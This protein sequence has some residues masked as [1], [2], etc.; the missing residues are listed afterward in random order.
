M[1][2]TF[3]TVGEGMMRSPRFEAM[4]ALLSLTSMV[5]PVESQNETADMST[6]MLSGASP[7]T[8]VNSAST[9]LDVS[10]STSPATQTVTSSGAVRADVTEN[11]AAAESMVMPAPSHYLG[12]Q[13]SPNP[14]QRRDRMVTTQQR[15]HPPYTGYS[16]DVCPQPER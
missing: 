5:S 3:R 4:H 12:G 8:R 14:P 6:T 7:R 2:I 1:S 16:S 13:G 9:S 11:G 10:R 15:F